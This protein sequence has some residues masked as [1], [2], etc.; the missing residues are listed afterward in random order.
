MENEEGSPTK[1]PTKHKH[2]QATPTNHHVLTP[3]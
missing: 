2:H 1:T 3:A